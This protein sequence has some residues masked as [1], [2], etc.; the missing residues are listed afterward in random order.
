[1]NSVRGILILLLQF[2]TKTQRASAGF[3][4]RT[5]EM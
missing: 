2:V 3:F 1:M 5:F 4:V